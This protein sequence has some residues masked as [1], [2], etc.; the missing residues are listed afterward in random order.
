MRKIL[1]NIEG[2]WW[3][4]SDFSL[5]YLCRHMVYTVKPWRYVITTHDFKGIHTTIPKKVIGVL[6]VNTHKLI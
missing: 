1:K 5:R 6:V 4:T 2:T 3:K